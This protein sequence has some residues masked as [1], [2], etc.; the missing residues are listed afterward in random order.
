MSTF[1]LMTSRGQ[2]KTWVPAD[3]SVVQY[4]YRVY[5]MTLTARGGTQQLCTAGGNQGS[6]YFLDVSLF[7][8]LRTIKQ[9]LT[10]ILFLC[11]YSRLSH[12][13]YSL[14]RPDQ[15]DLSENLAATQGLANMI[16]EAQRLF[17]VQKD[18]IGNCTAD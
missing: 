8:Y 13:K 6:D 4:I 2:E 1:F 14:G 7:V 10:S 3:R 12:R 16:T 15:R 17:Q 9:T 11:G 18:A 5:V